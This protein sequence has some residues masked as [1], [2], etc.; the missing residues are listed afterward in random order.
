M[1]IDKMIFFLQVIVTWY[2][3][4]DPTLEKNL[5]SAFSV[6]KAYPWTLILQHACQDIAGKNLT[7]LVIVTI[8]FS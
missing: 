3:T 1:K 4:R 8:S 7:N 2:F 5:I 6:T